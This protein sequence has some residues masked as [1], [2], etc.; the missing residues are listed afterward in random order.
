MSAGFLLSVQR[1][2]LKI[3]RRYVNMSLSPSSAHFFSPDFTHPMLSHNPCLPASATP[4]P[5]L[6]QEANDVAIAAV[7]KFELESD[8]ANSITYVL[9]S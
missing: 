1:I 5:S 4:H 6:Q 2:C 9:P 8:I 3:C 7:T